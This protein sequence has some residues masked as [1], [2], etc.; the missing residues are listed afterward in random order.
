MA[1]AQLQIVSDLHLESCNGYDIFQVDPQAPYLALVGDIGYVKEE[2]FFEFLR[3]HIKLFRIVFLV[4]GNHEAYGSSWE[5]VKSRIK[6]FEAEANE[7]FKKGDSSGEFVLLDQA[8]YDISPGLSILGCTL[9]SKV[10]PEQME[11]VSFGLNDFYHIGDWSVEAHI[12]AHQSDLDWLNREN[13]SISHSEPDRKF[14]VLTHFCPSVSKEVADPRHEGSKISSAFM[15][16]LADEMCWRTD[17]VKLWAFGHTH[18]NCDFR[19][20]KTRKRVISNQMG[21][22]FSQSKRV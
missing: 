3:I 9:F 16:D 19:D 8:R 10:L 17:A 15:S 6:S 22:Y 21:Y 7:L 14:V 13:E 1:E 18:F 4:T 11:S 2:G 20:E 12:E 5:K